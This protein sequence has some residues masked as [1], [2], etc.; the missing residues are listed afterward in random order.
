M[1]KIISAFVAANLLILA[2]GVGGTV[3]YDA[4][5]AAWLKATHADHAEFVAW[6]AR[7]LAY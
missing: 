6:R 2:I 4:R 5:H 7:M 3:Y 1:S